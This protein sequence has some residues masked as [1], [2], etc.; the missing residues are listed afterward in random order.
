VGLTP[1]TVAGL[2]KVRPVRPGSRVALV[3]PASPF[4]RHEFDAGLVELRRLGLE[5]LYDETIFEREPIV[6]GSARTR[7]TALRRAWARQDVDAI[8]GVRGGYGSVEVLPFLDADRI[9]ASRT[10]FIGYSDLTSVHSYLNG[11]VGVT[12]VHGA[13][14][15]RRLAAGPGA[16]DVA[17]FIASLGANPIGELTPEGIEVIRHGEAV[18]PI[19]GGTLTQLA[20]SMGTPYAFNPPRGHVL[21]L[22]EVGERPYRLRRMLMQLLLG[23]HLATASAL[24]FGQLPRCDE[25]GSPLTAREVLA[26]L[27]A[28]FPGPVLAGFPSGHTVTPLVSLPFGVQTRVITTSPPR[29]VLEESAAS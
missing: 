7:A 29:L 9:L 16:Y 19:G 17:S 5:P 1:R 25:P 20:A 26:D 18:G 12:S 11:H 15:E 14:I 21:F 6:A 10:A 4:D 24:V 13:M 22:D 8:I 27:F 3:A 23:G 2:V 28:E